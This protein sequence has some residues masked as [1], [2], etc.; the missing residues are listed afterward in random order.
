M[1]ITPIASGSSGNA[2]HITDG[3][4]SLLL[5]AG[6]PLAK[7][8][9]GCGYTVT[10]LSGCLVTHAHGD[11]VKAAKSLARLGV[12]IY[13]SQGTI[14][15]AGLAGHRI[16]RVKSQE[17]F[18][19]GT[20]K[21]MPFDVEHDVPEPLGF[22]IRSEITQEK[23][24]YF[25]D[26]YFIRYRFVGLT[27]I[28]MEA[29]YDPEEMEQNVKSGRI[30]VSRAKRTVTSHM[31]IDTVLKTLEA[32]DLSHLQQVYLLHLSNDNSRAEEFKRRV[33]AL[34]GRETYIC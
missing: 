6:I 8:Q 28:M 20:F 24:L 4:S 32:F 18:T 13:T 22:L 7:I 12:N 31:S 27:H 15:A 3:R 2:Y 11:H 25:T 5:D 26:T 19:A 34:T 21:I 10:R 23:L 16:H 1:K 33:Q 14:D 17:A 29:N 9:E 30:D